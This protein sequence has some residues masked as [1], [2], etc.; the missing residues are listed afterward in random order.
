[1]PGAAGVELPAATRTNGSGAEIF[2][3]RE[4]IAARTAQNGLLI[5][6][7]LR[8]ARCGVICAFVVTLIAWKPFAAA[9]K[10][11]R[12]DVVR[13]VIMRAAR[14]K[15][16]IDAVDFDAV[17]FHAFRSRGHTSTSNDAMTQH[18]IMTAKPVLKEPVR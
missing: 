8:P 2:T 10:L 7:L 9:G 6:L 14:F 1:M 18:A 11:D 16:D 12:D 5:K 13:R 15:I 4:L 17:D 3:N